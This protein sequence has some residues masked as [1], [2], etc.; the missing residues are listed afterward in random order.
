LAPLF[1]LLASR[2]ILSAPSQAT[3]GS[4]WRFLHVIRDG[5]DVAFSDDHVTQVSDMTRRRGHL[6]HHCEPPCLGADSEQGQTNPNAFYDN[7]IPCQAPHG[8]FFQLCPA[9]YGADACAAALAP[10]QSASAALHDLAEGGGHLA[11]GPS[12]AE[13]EQAAV[14]KAALVVEWWGEVSRVVG[15]VCVLGCACSVKGVHTCY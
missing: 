14:R 3:L 13:V 1:P 4:R 11:E 5:R 2:V 12:E 10:P 7:P 15:E 8:Q 9:M 6:N